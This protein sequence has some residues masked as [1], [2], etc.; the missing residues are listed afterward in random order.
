MGK[1]VR[2]LDTPTSVLSQAPLSPESRLLQKVLGLVQANDMGEA[3]AQATQP[4]TCSPN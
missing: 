1:K 4:Q 3:A 2:E